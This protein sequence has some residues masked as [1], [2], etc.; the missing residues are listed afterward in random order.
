MRYAIGTMG[1]AFAALCILWPQALVADTSAPVCSKSSTMT[2]SGNI[3]SLETVREEP[4]A[5]AQTFFVIDVPSR[6]CGLKTINASVVGVTNCSVGNTIFITGEFS[7]PGQSSNMAW[8]RG[9]TP[10]QCYA[11]LCRR[12]PFEGICPG[13]I[14][15][16][17]VFYDKERGCEELICQYEVPFTSV[18]ECEATCGHPMH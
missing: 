8:I 15:F 3:R 11:D 18:K 12:K 5:K 17:A 14:S 2:V 7:P 1:A 9:N 10:V 4:Q 13:G 16:Q 6:T